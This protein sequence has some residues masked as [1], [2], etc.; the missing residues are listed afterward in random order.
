[1]RRYRLLLNYIRGVRCSHRFI[2]NLLKL[3]CEKTYNVQTLRTLAVEW[4]LKSR[5][6]HHNV[7][8]WFPNMFQFTH[9]EKTNARGGGN[10][11]GPTGSD[12]LMIRV[13]RGVYQLHPDFKIIK[14]LLEEKSHKLE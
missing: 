11:Y 3:G 9:N 13:S 1:M 8:Q 14:Y 10:G 2:R 6:V 12:P 4:K 7:K 5:D